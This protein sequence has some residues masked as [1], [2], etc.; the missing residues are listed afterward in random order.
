LSS[1]TPAAPPKKVLFQPF[2]ETRECFKE[3]FL[4]VGVEVGAGMGVG[5]DSC[6]L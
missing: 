6:R 3:S 4:S 2:S 1:L 5:V